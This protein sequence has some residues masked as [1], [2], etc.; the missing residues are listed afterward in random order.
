[1]TLRGRSD[2]GIARPLQRRGEQTGLQPE[3]HLESSRFRLVETTQYCARWSVNGYSAFIDLQNT[4]DCAVGGEVTLLDSSGASLTTLL[5]ALDLRS[6]TQIPVP[7]GLPAIFGSARL[8]HG[9]P[10]GAITGGIYMV[11]NGAAA[12]NYRWPFQ[13][14]RA[15]GT[16]D[17]K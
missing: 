6:A 12:A 4:S 11:N 7:T 3:R 9:G 14:V 2:P 16:T 10:Q 13:E 17:G 1:M 15:Y 5:F 8:T